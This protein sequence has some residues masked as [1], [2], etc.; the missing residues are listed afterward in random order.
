[1][2][3]RPDNR[4]KRR[5]AKRETSFKSPS[6]KFHIL[7]MEQLRHIGETLGGIK[8]LMLFEDEI[9][10]NNRQCRLLA[11]M[12]SL[13]FDSVSTEVK[14]HLRLE[15]KHTK[16]KTLENPLRELNRVFKEA[17]TYIRS[18]LEPGRDWWAKAVAL[19]GNMD[20]VEIHLHNLL[21]CLSVVLEAI[22]Y[23]GEFSGCDEKEIAR[24]KVL[25]RKKYDSELLDKKIFQYRFSKMLST[26]N[27]ISYIFY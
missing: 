25:L 22:E 23:A 14:A 16:W 6:S 2:L 7:R 3:L 9:H 18:C 20:C 19:A 5:R 8:T 1:V 4:E 10:I 12:L 13:A 11:D 15:E 27:F 17:D 24:K 21:W 26:F